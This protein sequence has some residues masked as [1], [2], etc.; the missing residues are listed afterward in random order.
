[1]PHVATTDG[2]KLFYEEAGSGA[3]LIFV[4]E[5]AGDHRSFEPQLRYFSRSFRCVAFNAR[6]YPPSDVPPNVDHYSQERAVEDIRDVLDGLGIEKAHLLGVSMGGSAV[7]HFGL[8]H[9]GRALSL[10]VAA[11]GSGSVPE[12]REQ[13]QAEAETMARLIEANGMATVAEVLAKGSTRIQHRDKDPLGWKE[14]SDHLAQHS[15]TGTALTL[16]GVQKGR[17]SLYD[18]AARLKLLS[19]PTLIM[20]GDEDESCIDPSLFLKRAIATSGLVILPKTGHNLNLEEPA[21]FN[22]VVQEFLMRVLAGGWGAREA[23]ATTNSF[24]G[25][26]P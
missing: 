26:E 20:V 1:M 4:H 18:E 8:R 14:F 15:A 24:L 7:L 25:I 6:G 16:R 21:L 17:G 23:S 19:V 13:F 12:R 22:A 11:A 5:L 2:V 9:P 10:V 3:P